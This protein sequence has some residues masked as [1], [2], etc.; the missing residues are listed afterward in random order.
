MKRKIKSHSGTVRRPIQLYTEDFESEIEVDVNYDYSAYE[1]MTH[2]DPGQ[3]E[4]CEITSVKLNGCDLLQYLDEDGI[5]KMEE[6]IM[7]DI[8][9]AAEAWEESYYEV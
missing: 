1:S 4:D 3:P 9:E 7:I 5:K 8:A 2:N 6:H